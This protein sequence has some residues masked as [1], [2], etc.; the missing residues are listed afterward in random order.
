MDRIGNQSKMIYELSFVVHSAARP[1]GSKDQFGREAC[2]GVKPYRQDVRFKALDIKDDGWSLKG[3]FALDVT[4]HFQRPKSHFTSKGTLTK[5]AP[6][7]PTGR[8]IGDVD[9]LLR[10]TCDA[11][12]GVLIS[13]DSEIVEITGRKL[14]SDYPLTIISLTHLDTP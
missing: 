11:L 4:F 1:Q 13:D 7:H 5:S 12:T 6:L 8:N 9:K 14:Y 10:S 3:P 2:K